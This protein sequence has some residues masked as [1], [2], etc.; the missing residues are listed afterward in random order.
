MLNNAFEQTP[1]M[2]IPP[3]FHQQLALTNVFN[4]PGGAGNATYADVIRD[5]AGNWVL[6]RGAVHGIGRETNGI[7]VRDDEKTFE[8]KVRSVGADTTILAFDNAVESEL[9]TSRFTRGM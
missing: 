1:V 7:T 6:Q 4:K 3:A 8:A 2:Y 5:G 9:D